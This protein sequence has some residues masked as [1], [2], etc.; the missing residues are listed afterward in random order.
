MNKPKNELP[1]GFMDKLKEANRE[2]QMISIVLMGPFPSSSN[3]NTYLLVICDWF[4]KC[5]VL[6]P[7]R[8]ASNVICH[9][10]QWPTQFIGTF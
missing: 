7:L 6:V 2:W 5:P 1:H 3:Q 4:T 8:N 10:W 9:C